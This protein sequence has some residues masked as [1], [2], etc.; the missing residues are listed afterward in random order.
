M[1]GTLLNGRYRLDAELGRGGMGTVYRAHDTLLDR[2]V[3]VKVLSATGL[4]TDGRAR[5]LREAQAA[6][7]L[8]HPNIVTVHDVAESDGGPSEEAVPFIV[9]ELV[10]GPS[11]HDRRPDTLEETVAV[12]RQVCAALEHAHERSIVHRD[13]KPENILLALD[14][15]GAVTAAKLSDFGLA[16]SIATRLSVEGAVAGTVFYLAPELA[17]GQP[18]DGRADLYALGVML[19]ELTTGRLPFVAG[20]PVAVISQHLR[21]PPVPPRARDEGIPPALDAL[22]LRLLSKHP[23]ERPASAAKVR[24]ALEADDILNRQVASAHEHSVLDRIERGRMVGRERELAQMSA[25]WQKAAAGEGQTLLVSGEPGIGKTRLVRELCTEVLIGGGRVLEGGCHAEGI[26]PYAPFA[27]ILRRAFGNGAGQDLAAA[28]PDFVLADLL[29]LAPSLRQRF[30]DVPPNP[31]L[32]PK[33]EQLR[34]F[35]SMVAICTALSEGAPLLLVLE[36]AHWSDGGTLS[37]LC[38]LARRTRQRRVMIVATYRE[39]EL[40]TLHPF[41]EGLQELNRRKLAIR[42]KL[43]RL[44]REGTHD[45]LATLFAEE[46]TPEFLEGIYHET[47]GNP[48]FVEEVCRALVESGR[49]YF[50]G[51]RWHRPSMQELGIPQSVRVAIQSRVARLSSQ[52]RETL[53]LAAIVGREFAFDTVAQA[54]G[55]GEDALIDVLEIAERAQLVGE[56]SSEAGGTFGFTHGLIPAAL[57]ESVSGLRRRRLHRRVAEAVEALHP[58]D[59]SQLGALAYHYSQAGVEDK[60][61]HYLTRAGDRARARYANQDAI[62]YYSQAL[63]LAPEADGARR[64]GLL[65][66]RERV[67][68]RLGQR[69]AQRQDLAELAA[70]AQGLGGEQQAEVAVRRARCANWVCDYPAAIALAREAVE[71]AR[72]VG[73]AGLEA[74]GHLSWGA[75]L[76]VQS[77]FAGSREHVEAVLL[78]SRATGLPDMEAEALRGLG[79]ASCLEFDWVGGRHYQEQ[80]LQVYQQIDDQRGV[81][82]VVHNLGVICQEL[83]DYAQALAYFEQGLRRWREMGN[84]SGELYTLWCSGYV[85]RLLGQYAQAREY[86][87]QSLR[88][89]REIEEGILECAALYELGE[90]CRRVGDS[91]AAQEYA[92]EAWGLVQSLGSPRDQVFALQ[93]LGALHQDLGDPGAAR[94]CYEQALRIPPDINSLPHAADAI[95]SLAGLASVALA[96]GDPVKAQ[97]QV[98]EILAYLDGGGVLSTDNWPFWVY[99]TCYRVLRAGGD[100]RALEILAT[101]HS[102]LQEHAARTPDEA[103]RRSFLENVAENRAIV[104]EWEARPG[105]GAE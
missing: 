7:G 24:R 54:S 96:V 37:L 48:F 70:L 57:I 100:P 72:A 12:A 102:L 26:G 1:I 79:A 16:R 74:Q 92:E 97:A 20:D 69:D 30:P 17:L 21:A 6:A 31:A 42:L 81:G 86:V 60:A 58:D 28:L 51:G 52:V 64:Y 50:E 18:Y 32:D 15:S 5:L 71:Q 56:L 14:T 44:G 29:T 83:G 82:R 38:H 35:E 22:I 73:H 85:R 89:A 19:Y 80:A 95:A 63:E 67:Y 8:N 84:R 76:F 59:G 68:D 75:A 45:M 103:T 101:A 62:R 10:E 93:F 47:E 65:L 3:A 43:S 88:V 9:M 33:A 46:I 34:L 39:V 13:L 11:L 41:H 66:E 99:L 91:A 23:R 25:L 105:D 27:Q 77:D 49:L 2:D 90:L 87:E 78:L 4:G 61:L 53:S 104:A 40:D 94:A 98:A 55:V 36:D